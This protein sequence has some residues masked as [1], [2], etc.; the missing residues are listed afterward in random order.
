MKIFRELTPKNIKVLIVGQDPYPTKG[1]ANGISF[2]TN[3]INSIPASL[4]NIHTEL[5]IEGYEINPEDPQK[6]YLEKWVK[7]GV[8]LTNYSL[9]VEAEMKSSHSNL[10]KKFTESFCKYLAIRKP[11][12]VVILLGTKAKLLKKYFNE[13]NVLITSH[14]APNS[15][16][17]GFYNS[18]IFRK[19]NQRLKELGIEEIQW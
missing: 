13:L 10:W 5:N 1:I 14:P 3:R 16:E 12:M 15:C 9:T 2:S 11:N 6:Y 19:C 7:Q 8:F 4:K 18:M 17:L